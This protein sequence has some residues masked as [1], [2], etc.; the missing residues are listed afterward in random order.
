MT[1]DRTVALSPLRDRRLRETM[2]AASIAD[3]TRAPVL[4]TTRTSRNDQQYD[5]S[6]RCE[7]HRNNPGYLSHP[8]G[9]NSK[10][11]HDI[12]A[13]KEHKQ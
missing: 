6:H 11:R 4:W 2:A 8:M 9:E 13:S 10:Q 1:R 5:L 7:Q 3:R 12:K